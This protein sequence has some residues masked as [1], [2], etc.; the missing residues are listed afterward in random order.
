MHISKWI[1]LSCLVFVPLT[2]FAQPEGMLYWAMDQYPEQFFQYTSDEETS[3]GAISAM[4]YGCRQFNGGSGTY[5]GNI[6]ID[7]SGNNFPAQKG[8]W[9]QNRTYIGI[10]DG[11]YYTTYLYCNGNKRDI[12]DDSDCQGTAIP[13]EKNFG[14]PCSSE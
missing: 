9:C 3:N 1:I 11:A 5:T 8:G 13:P 4:D 14:G 6:R 12:F 10:M 2:A 7:G